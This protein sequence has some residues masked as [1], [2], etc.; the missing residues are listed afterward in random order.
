MPTIEL[1]AMIFD[2][3]M[4][5][6]IGHDRR[7]AAFIVYLCLS[8][9][10]F[11]QPDWSVRISHQTLARATGLSRSAVQSAL[12]HLNRRQLVLSAR[13]T[14]TSVP[15]HK[16]QRPWLRLGRGRKGGS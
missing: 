15:L 16:V 2:A 11:D 4:P 6:L 14:P 7:P 10:A 8:R 9:R 12:A 1:D 13:T 5:D 3:V